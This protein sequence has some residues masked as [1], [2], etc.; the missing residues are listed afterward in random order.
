MRGDGSHKSCYS[1]SCS[2][3]VYHDSQG[4]NV[5]FCNNIR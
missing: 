2:C 3:N 4:D 1:L 5:I